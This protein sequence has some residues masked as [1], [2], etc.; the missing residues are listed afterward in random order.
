MNDYYSS[1]Q[2]DYAY[3]WQLLKTVFKKNIKLS[4]VMALLV[5]SLV[6]LYSLTFEPQ[7]R[8]TTVMH[9]APQT[10]AVFNLRELL[11]NRRDPAFRETQIGIIRSRVLISKVV[12]QFSP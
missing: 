11:L 7:Y 1:S 8:A 10:T 6:F 5:G 12:E 2:I 4:L 9:V 3:Y